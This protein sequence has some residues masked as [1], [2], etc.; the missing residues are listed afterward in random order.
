VYEPPE[1]AEA[2]CFSAFSIKPQVKDNSAAK[3]KNE[4]KY[5][6]GLQLTSKSG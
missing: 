2:K 6:F 5:K 1:A 4:M 3:R